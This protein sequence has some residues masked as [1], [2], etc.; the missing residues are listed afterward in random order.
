MGVNPGI[1]HID[2]EA[3]HTEVV[4]LEV[5]MLSYMEPGAVMHFSIEVVTGVEH[6][7]K[8]VY[9]RNVGLFANTRLRGDAV[10]QAILLPKVDIRELVVGKQLFLLLI[11]YICFPENQG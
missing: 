7:S 5:C 3:S 6:Y 9:S 8:I 11:V 4:E 10:G 2:Q 1:L